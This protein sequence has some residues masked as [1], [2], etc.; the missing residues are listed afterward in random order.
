MLQFST[1]WKPQ[2]TIQNYYTDVYLTQSKKRTYLINHYCEA[3]VPSGF[4]FF[5]SGGKGP[6]PLLWAGSQDARVKI[7]TGGI[8]NFLNQCLNFIVYNIQM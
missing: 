2:I 6:Q 8:P 7:T 4:F 1:I 5:L 3:G